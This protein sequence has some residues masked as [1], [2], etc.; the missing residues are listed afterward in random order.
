[1]ELQVCIKEDAELATS[2]F[3]A[4]ESRLAAELK[5]ST[6]LSG[7]ARIVDNLPNDG[8]VV[9]DQRTYG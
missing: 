8:T 2:E 6:Q 7:T 3:G 5:A 4:L 1:M 9:D